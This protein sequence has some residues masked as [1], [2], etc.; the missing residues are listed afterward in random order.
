MEEQ[1]QSKNLVQQYQQT[2]ATYI[3]YV[4]DSI[5]VFEK[6]FCEDEGFFQRSNFLLV[7]VKKGS[8]LITKTLFLRWMI[9]FGTFDFT[10]LWKIDYKIQ[11][12]LRLLS[13]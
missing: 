7:L 13:T 6:L 9:F 5:T 10:H 3:K 2:T 12:I 8:K 1:G 4:L 11:I